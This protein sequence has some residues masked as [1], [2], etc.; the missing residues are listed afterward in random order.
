MFKLLSFFT[1]ICPEAPHRPICTKFDFGWGSAS[2]PAR[3][4]Y[5]APHTPSQ[6]WAPYKTTEPIRV[7]SRVYKHGPIGNESVLKKY[8]K[9]RNIFSLT[10][11]S[12]LVIS[13]HNT[14]RVLFDIIASVYFIWEKYINILSLE[15]DSPGNRGTVPIVSAHF[16]SIFLECSGDAAFCRIYAA[17]SHT[18]YY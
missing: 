11:I 16:R 9:W 6:P 12:I 18:Y 8:N 15:M 2:D 3:G 13:S 17:N 1:F 4:A 7:P 5:S 10:A 14:F